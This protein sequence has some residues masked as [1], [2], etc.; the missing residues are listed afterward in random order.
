MHRLT[1]LVD[2]LIGLQ[3]DNKRVLDTH[4]G[5]LL[6]ARAFHHHRV[7]AGIKLRQHE[8]DRTFAIDRCRSPC[9]L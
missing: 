1:R 4:V 2:R 8:F 3:E 9:H 7:V 5:A 6:E